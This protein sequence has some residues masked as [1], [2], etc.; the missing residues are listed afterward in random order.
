M[1]N[2]KKKEEE[3]GGGGGGG[4]NEQGGKRTFVARKIPVSS[5]SFRIPARKKRIDNRW[6]TE[7][8]VP[9][10][11]FCASARRAIDRRGDPLSVFGRRATRKG[12]SEQARRGRGT[13]G[14]NLPV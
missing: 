4:E 2:E 1:K 9:R 6:T 13:P 5:E 10:G 3:E 11:S 7:N 14:T 12:T 8:D